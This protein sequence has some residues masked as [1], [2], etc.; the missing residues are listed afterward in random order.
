MNIK[1]ELSNLNS[2]DDVVKIQNALANQE[3]ILAVEIKLAENSANVV[4]DD[5]YTTQYVVLDVVESLGYG[6]KSISGKL[7]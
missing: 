5:F 7:K 3:G 1:M 6:V 2:Q 4:Y